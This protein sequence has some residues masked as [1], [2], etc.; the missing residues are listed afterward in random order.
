MSHGALG[1]CNIPSF[2]MGP[3]SHSRKL[4]HPDW[5]VLRHPTSQVLGRDV[6]GSAS[7]S[8]EKLGWLFRCDL[9]LQGL[10]RKSNRIGLD[11]PQDRGL[12]SLFKK[13]LYQPNPSLA[14]ILEQEKKRPQQVFFIILQSNRPIDG[15]QAKT[16][17]EKSVYYVYCRL[18]TDNT[19][20]R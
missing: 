5:H 3:S 18:I 4:Q 16:S 17:V 14:Q 7:Y 2:G 6:M 11:F 1:W 10:H 12:Y 20:Y 8:M 13:L 15:I 9:K 19:I